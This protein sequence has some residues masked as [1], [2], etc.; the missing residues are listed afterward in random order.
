MIDY[1]ETKFFVRHWLYQNAITQ[2]IQKGVQ[3]SYK[4]IWEF[5]EAATCVNCYFEVA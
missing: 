4:L 2:Y 1:T 3:G 5:E